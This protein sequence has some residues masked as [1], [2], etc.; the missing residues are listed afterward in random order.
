M[1]IPSVTDIQGSPSLSGAST[2]WGSIGGRAPHPNTT[3]LPKWA[4]EEII[5]RHT[6]VLN[7]SICP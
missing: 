5:G 3:N 2:N 7:N 4:S 6:V 1:M